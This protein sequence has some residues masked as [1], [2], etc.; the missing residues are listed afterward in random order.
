M[1]ETSH[2]GSGRA[3]WIREIAAEVCAARGIGVPIE[4]VCLY[5]ILDRPDWEDL[6]H[7]HNSGLWDLVPNGGNRLARVLNPEYAHEFAA[8][9]DLLAK[10]GCR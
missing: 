5:P 1:A 6:S 8:A 4:G 10:L 7:W 2:F 9:R 3:R